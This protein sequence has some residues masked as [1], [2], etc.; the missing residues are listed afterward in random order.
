MSLHHHHPTDDLVF[1]YAG[2]SLDEAKS[3]VVATHLALCPACRGAVADAEALGGA[4][5]EDMAG[6][7]LAG[8]ALA[9]TLQR[10][11]GRRDA[12]P[13]PLAVAPGAGTTGLVLPQPLRSYVGGDL[14]DVAWKTLGPGI[15][16]R[17]LIRSATGATARL[18]RIQPGLAVFNHGHSGQEL[19]LV[20]QGSY[21]SGGRQFQR[22]DLEVADDTVEHAPVA[23]SEAVCI[24][25]AVTEAPLRFKNLIGRLMQPFIGI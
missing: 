5:I 19:T 2:G 21:R 18:L 13:R 15:Q 8:D 9:A 1:A 10:A 25:L 4:L 7:P 14:A 23:G 6:E 3:L 22:G 20:L 16:H 11:A 12:A 24:C 17:E